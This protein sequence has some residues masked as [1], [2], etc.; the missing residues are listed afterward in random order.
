MWDMRIH[1]HVIKVFSKLDHICVATFKCYSEEGYEKTMNAV[2][3]AYN[4]SYITM[5]WEGNE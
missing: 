5:E 3:E 1:F 2:K 4:D